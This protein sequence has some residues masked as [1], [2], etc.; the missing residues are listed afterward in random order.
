MLSVGLL[1]N[2]AELLPELNTVLSK[3]GF[4]SRVRTL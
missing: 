3:I 1:L 2:A 4:Y